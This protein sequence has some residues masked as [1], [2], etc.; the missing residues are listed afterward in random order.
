MRLALPPFRFRETALLTIC[1][2]ATAC[3][4]LKEKEYPGETAKTICDLVYD[5]A[6]ES[7]MEPTASRN[8]CVAAIE[9]STKLA[10]EQAKVDGLTFDG[11]CAEKGLNSID[12]LACDYPDLVE[13]PACKRPCK[14]YYG[15]EGKGS[16]CTGSMSG[17]DNCKQGLSC[18]GGICTNPCDEVDY[19]NIGEECFAG[20][21]EEGGYCLY[22]GVGFPTCQALPTNGQACTEAG[23][24]CADDHFCDTATD[25]ANPTCTSEPGIGE[26]CPAGQCR[27]LGIVC[28]SFT[29]P[30]MP[31]CASLPGQGQTCLGGFQCEF[32]MECDTM[33][34]PANPVCQRAEA[35]ICSSW[36]PLI[37][38]MP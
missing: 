31:V 4:G 12:D 16:S 8:E 26:A 17:Y 21:C 34:D 28:D 5:C 27:G 22:T 18:D 10:Q 35:L 30:L 23:N 37:P 3:G 29:D 33:T 36:S 32:G 7:T 19:P 1:A 15:P 20:M 14:L 38:P 11:E 6:C 13:D 24:E 2:L 9:E 25:P